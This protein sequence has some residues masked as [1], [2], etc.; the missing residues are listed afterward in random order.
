[1]AAHTIARAWDSERG[2]AFSK[3]VI[4]EKL[5]GKSGFPGIVLADDFSMK[6]ASSGGENPGL[7]ALEAGCDMIM[8]WS[9]DL[10]NQHK[11]I[12]EALRDGLLS[13]QRLIDAASRITGQK[14]RFGLVKP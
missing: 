12:L 10:Y 11:I 2:A 4:G 1:M 5:V 14:L 7:L 6:A 8:V 9:P 3:T 13:R